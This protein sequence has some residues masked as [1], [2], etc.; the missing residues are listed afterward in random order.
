[1]VLEQAVLQITPGREE[2]FEEA[3]STVA[4]LLAGSPG[5]R[6]VRLHR[7][8]EAPSRYLLLVEW[9]RLEDHM[10]GFRTSAAYEQYRGAL[11]GFYEVPAAVEHYEL[12]QQH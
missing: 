1:M 7:G 10:V 9:E 6:G 12:R 4:A 8:I 11:V 3:F 2:A 5:C